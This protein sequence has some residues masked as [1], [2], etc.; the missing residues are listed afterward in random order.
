[1]M[2]GLAANKAYNNFNRRASPG[3]F[4]KTKSYT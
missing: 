3:T 2:K 1:M 4:I